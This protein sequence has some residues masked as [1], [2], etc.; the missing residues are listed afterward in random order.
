MAYSFI[1]DTQF[2]QAAASPISAPAITVTAGDFLI[3][4][5]RG[6]AGAFQT[7]KVVFTDGTGGDTWQWAGLCTNGGGNGFQVGYCIGAIGGSTVVT[8]TLSASNMT[9]IYVAEYSGVGGGLVGVPAYS[10][11]FQNGVSTGANAVVSGNINV[12]IQPAL[13]WGFT[14]D[15]SRASP[16]PY[17]AGTSPIAFTDRAANLWSAQTICNRVEDARLT[18]TGNAQATFTSSQTDAVMTMVLAFSEQAQNILGWT[19]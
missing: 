16:N 15:Q 2:E 5:V 8:G 9:S 12:T 19:V 17:S 13:L 10:S 3:C 7:G 6:N 1:Q 4:A 14:M 18:A 11:N